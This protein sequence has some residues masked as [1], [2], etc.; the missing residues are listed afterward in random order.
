MLNMSIYG[1]SWLQTAA[2]RVRKNLQSQQQGQAT[3]EYL[4][5]M[6]MAAVVVFVVTKI[7]GSSGGGNPITSLVGDLLSG[8][9]G[10]AGKIIKTFL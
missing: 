7:F 1:Y 10:N 4:L 2:S 3:S 8:L 6:L 5:V 9:V